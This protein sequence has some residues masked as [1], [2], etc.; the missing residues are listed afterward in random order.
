M[1]LSKN[2]VLNEFLQS[3]LARRHG[4]KMNPSKEHVQNIQLLVTNILQPLRTHIGSIRINSGWRS[5]ELNRII[6]GAYK[7]THNEKGEK[8][9]VPTSQHCKGQ[10]SDIKFVKNGIMKNKII[11]DAVLKLDLD[12]DQMINEF[13]YSWIHISFNKNGNRRQILE[14]YKDKNNKTKY[15]SIKQIKSI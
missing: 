2:F 8:I 3:S 9:Y 10:A 1:R 14:A 7:W 11:F 4:L 5:A 6:G 15:K 12:F 13:D